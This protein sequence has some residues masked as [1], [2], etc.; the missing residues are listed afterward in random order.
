MT[1]Q[2]WVYLGLFGAW[3]VTELI[4]VRQKDRPGKPRTL[5]AVLRWIVQPV[6]G[7]HMHARWL[8]IVFLAW[9]RPHILGH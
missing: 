6:A 9:F 3:A 5:S 1:W 8:F 4:A 7:W 2:A